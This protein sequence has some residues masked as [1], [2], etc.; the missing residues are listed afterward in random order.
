MNKENR[1]LRKQQRLKAKGRIGRTSPFYFIAEGFK[2]VF[3]HGFMS[4]AAVIIVIACLL[5][6]GMFLLIVL[7]VDAIVTDL[8]QDNEIVAY[9]DETYTESQARS[10]S[11]EINLIANVQSCTFGTRQE[12]LDAFIAKYEDSSLF[13]GTDAS[14]LR[15]RF[16]IVLNDITLTEETV[17]QIENIEG[18]AKVRASLA[19]A[20]GFA[21]VRNVLKIVTYAITAILLVISVFIISNTVRLTTQNRK[22][23]I[24]IMR[25]VGATNSFI[26]WPFVIQGIILGVVSAAAAYFMQWSLYDL[27]RQ[28]VM[29]TDLLSIIDVLPFGYFSSIMAIGDA[30]VG[31]FVGAGGSSFAITRYLK[32]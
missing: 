8:E 31:I 7:N 1:K 9:V 13:E 27:V 5:I 26:R 22:D 4:F 11:S 20:R 6:T 17:E 28:S 21:A 10:L 3:K 19:L 12:A 18:V 24:N 16:Y 14:A 32:K 25:M 2:S 29:R 15:D 23:E 30:A